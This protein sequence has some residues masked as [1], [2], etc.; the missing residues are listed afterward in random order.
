MTP[1]EREALIDRATFIAAMNWKKFSSAASARRVLSRWF[2]H[3]GVI[4]IKTI[5][6]EFRRLDAERRAKERPTTNDRGRA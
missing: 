5:R 2:E 1:T 6:A 4:P 3:R